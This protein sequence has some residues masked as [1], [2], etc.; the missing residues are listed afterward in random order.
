MS[1]LPQRATPAEHATLCAGAALAAAPLLTGSDAAV[2]ADKLVAVQ[3][4]G[5]FQRAAQREKFVARVTAELAKVHHR[6]YTA[7]HV[8]SAC[9]DC[10][11]SSLA[12]SI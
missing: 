7:I 12:S 3:S 6:Q 9:P 5:T 2:A 1:V 10:F 11:Y 8:D 4:L